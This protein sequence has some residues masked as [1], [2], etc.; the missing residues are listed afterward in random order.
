MRLAWS[1]FCL[2]MLAMI[3]VP[4]MC[5]AAWSEHDQA[6]VLVK[7]AA[8]LDGKAIAQEL[9]NSKA[10]VPLEL[11][12]LRDA[13]G[14]RFEPVF[15]LPQS[16]RVRMTAYDSLELGQYFVVHLNSTTSPIDAVSACS[17]MNEIE[18]IELN[19]LARRLEAATLP[20]DPLVL[21]QWHYFRIAL[22]LAWDITHGASFVTVAVLDDGFDFVHPDLNGTFRINQGEYQ[23]FAGIDDDGNG[24]I[25]DVLGW[26]FGDDDFNVYTASTFT[27]G[28]HVAGTIAALTNNGVGVAGA[29]WNAYLLPVRVFNSVTG[30]ASASDV[31]S[32]VYYAVLM[33]AQV[34]NM[35]LGSYAYNA[36][37]DAALQF[38]RS[39]SILNVAAAGN[40]DSSVVMF[41]AS[42]FYAIS[43]G[44]T[45]SSDTR[46]HW[47][48][49]QGS[50]FGWALQLVA[51]GD[52]VYSTFPTWFGSYG[53]STGTSMAAPHVSGLASLILSVR[54]TLT[55]DSV[56]M[57]MALGAD[58]QRGSSAEDTPGWDPYH[59]YGRINAYNSIR[60]ALGQCVCKCFG[61]PR[62]DGLPNVQDVV[63]TVNAAFRGDT[64]IR[65]F[66]CPRE[67]TD[68]T[69]NGFTNIQDVVAVVNVV[70]RGGT[71]EEFYG[72][73]CQ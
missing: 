41:P 35:S 36:T 59:G 12:S 62:C 64:P 13:G 66:G 56:Y 15:P 28:T 50:N 40:D 58:D 19:H 42:S 5:L 39:N 46:F 68:V 23:K 38:A 31:A 21:L 49:S 8:R 51:P 65:D 9:V 37:E 6:T 44:A 73:P 60:L 10:S 18:M 26:D 24:F 55:P 70:F 63:A 43:V 72:D 33:N 57:Y 25:D 30:S 67:R 54:P 27:H 3:H 20:N 53:S 29:D 2:G 17:G 11:S 45:N 69:G 48:E 16:G 1:V 61:D 71:A 32:G 14:D 22:P 34:I 7:L 4:S 47:N 52:G